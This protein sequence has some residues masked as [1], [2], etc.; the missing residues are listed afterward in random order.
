MRDFGIMRIVEHIHPKTNKE[1]RVW[2]L[3]VFAVAIDDHEMGITHVLNGKDHADNA[4]KE[5][6]I[7]QYLSWQPPIY[8]HWGRINFEGLELSTSK[9]RIAIE[10]GKYKGWDDIR[11]PF[12]PALRKRGYQPHAFRQFALEVGLSLTDKTVTI[13]EFWKTINAFNKDSIDPTAN[14]YFFIENPRQITIG[15]A[16]HRKLQLDLHPNHP[17][18]GQ[19]SF[20]T[21]DSFYISPPDLAELDEKKIHR[22][23]DCFNFKKAGAKFQ[24]ISQPYEEYKNSLLQGE[25]IHWLPE[26]TVPVEVVLTDGSSLQGLGE[27]SL[28]ALHP[29]DI[30]QFERRYFVRVQEVTTQKITVWQLHR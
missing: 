1:Q 22:L 7:M 29:G 20:Q 5:Q 25:I 9:T 21:K 15:G 2:P 6:I 19:R 10:E 4:I 13:E 28:A 30:V 11:L 12:L 26:K 24:Y 3:M 17:E 18:R 8:R 27:E 23:M 16:P 14:R